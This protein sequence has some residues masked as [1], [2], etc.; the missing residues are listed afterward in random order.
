M[1]TRAAVQVIVLDTRHLLS[2]QDAGS[3]VRDDTVH[4][5]QGMWSLSLRLEAEPEHQWLTSGS[6]FIS[7]GTLSKL[8]CP[9]MSVSSVKLG[10]KGF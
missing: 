4:R 5:E 9:S 7:C 8:L 6:A 10:N 3:H 2:T 1:P